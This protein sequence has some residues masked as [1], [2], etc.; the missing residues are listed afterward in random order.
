MAVGSGFRDVI[1]ADMAA[2]SRLVLDHH[3]LAPG[4]RQ[5]RGQDAGKGVGAAPWGEGDDDVNGAG[6]EGLRKRRAGENE[7]EGQRESAKNRR[8]HS[9]S[10]TAL[11]AP[12]A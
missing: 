1:G 10:K 7:T 3:R 6:R 9:T 12:D 4:L 5:P 8:S 11:P 2:R